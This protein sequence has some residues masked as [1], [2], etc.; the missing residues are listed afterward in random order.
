MMTEPA[1]HL[2]AGFRA[3]IAAADYLI[4]NKISFAKLVLS[5]LK[6]TKADGRVFFEF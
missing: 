4:T 2:S 1:K 3:R 5:K 6:M